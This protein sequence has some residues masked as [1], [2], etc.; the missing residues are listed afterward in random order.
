MAFEII[1]ESC[2][3]QTTG[4]YGRYDVMDRDAQPPVGTTIFVE[5][6][7]QDKTTFTPG[8]IVRGSDLIFNAAECRFNNPAETISP[9]QARRPED[10]V[11]FQG[12]SLTDI[13]VITSEASDPIDRGQR[14]CAVATYVTQIALAT[15][16]L[17][18][19]CPPF[20][21]TVTNQHP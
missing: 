15:A 16:Q 9:R 12:P 17:E 11:V 8:K 5:D 1:Y 10:P 20:G 6:A 18:A 3:D 21:V 14:A 7:P 2:P 4:L 19:V 13:V